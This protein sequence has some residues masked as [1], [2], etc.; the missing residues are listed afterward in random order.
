MSGF[1]GQ[2]QHQSET[3]IRELSHRVAASYM[4]SVKRGG[5]MS[6]AS[7]L[8]ADIGIGLAIGVAMHNIA[9]G[10]AIGIAMGVALGRAKRLPHDDA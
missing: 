8:A 4:L 10:L 7:A 9:I 2:A 3:L 5:G 6:R 1:R